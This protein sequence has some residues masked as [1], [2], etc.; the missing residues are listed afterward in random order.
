M[1][2]QKDCPET[3]VPMK[4]CSKKGNTFNSQCEMCKAG[5]EL[6]YAGP[7]KCQCSEEKNPVCGKDGKTY[8]N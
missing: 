4:V 1:T 8:D 2:L 3:C 7:C 6:D 5:E